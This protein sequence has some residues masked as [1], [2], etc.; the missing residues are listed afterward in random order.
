MWGPTFNRDGTS[1]AAAWATEGSVRV[2][3]LSTGSIE[4][5][6]GVRRANGAALSPDGRRIAVS[7]GEDPVVI[8]FDVDSGEEIL[9]LRSGQ[10]GIPSN[11][12]WSPD[13]RYITGGFVPHV[14]DASTGTLRS[15]LFGHTDEL[16]DVDWSRDASRLV[17]GAFD[18]TAK[19][20][21]FA[22]EG[23]A[24]EI[25]TLSAHDMTVVSGVAFSPD[26]ERVM[27]GDESLNAVAIWDVGPGGDAEW[28]NLASTPWG[29]V[30]FTPDGDHV[31]ASGAN[32]SVNLWEPTATLDGRLIRS[33]KG[34]G[35]EPACCAMQIEMSSDGATIAIGYWRGLVSVRDAVSGDELFVTRSAALLPE[36]DLS[37]TGDYVAIEKEDG[38]VEILDRSGGVV[39]SLRQG[40]SPLGTPV[41]PRW[42]IDR[43][44]DVVPGRSPR[45]SSEGLGLE[46]TAGRDHDPNRD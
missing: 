10:T 14:W 39:S 24:R 4:T 41:Q 27:A 44:G 7:S 34:S 45:E 46:A 21:E 29:D 6:R 32:N 26:G 38:S 35:S 9:R 17:T 37:P 40:G 2:L 15:L 31:L 18:G 30:S 42:P 3:D 11:V 5:I 23:V 28:A 1:V 36:F 25:M 8:V 20:W 16:M 12:S 43:Y 33:F 19:V 22:E 13:S